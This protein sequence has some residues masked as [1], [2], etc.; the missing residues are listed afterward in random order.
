[1]RVTRTAFSDV[2]AIA[3]AFAA[4]CSSRPSARDTPAAGTLRGVIKALRAHR[5]DLAETALDLVGD[6]QRAR[7]STIARAASLEDR[8]SGSRGLRSVVLSCQLFER[9]PCQVRR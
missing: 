6:R 4:R 9:P 3:I 8:I 7:S 5:R 1:M 2:P